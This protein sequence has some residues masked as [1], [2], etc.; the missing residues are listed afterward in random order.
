MDVSYDLEP[1]YKQIHRMGHQSNI[2]Y[3]KQNEREMIGYDERFALIC[4]R[5]HS[6]RYDSYDSKY[7]TLKYTLPL[8]CKDCPLAN[9]RQ[10][11]KVCKVKN[12]AD[13]RE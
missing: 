8:E 2:A 10:C 1:I 3:N 13:F 9:Q 11:Q 5:E 12:T 4:F 6:Y 7:G